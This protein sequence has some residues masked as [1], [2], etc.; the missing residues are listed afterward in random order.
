MNSTRTFLRIA[1]MSLFFSGALAW[2]A[3]VTGTVTN[4]TDGKPAAGDT[5]VLVDVQAGMRKWL[6]RPLTR[7][8]IIR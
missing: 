5:V 1:A 2:A 7:A 6:M 8:A 3:A 4:K